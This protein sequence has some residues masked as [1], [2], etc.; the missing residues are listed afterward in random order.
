MANAGKRNEMKAETNKAVSSSVKFLFLAALLMFSFSFI[1]A[2]SYK[3]GNE[4]NLQFAVNGT[5]SS[6]NVTINYP[7]ST[8]LIDNQIAT[9]GSG[10][11]NYTLNSSQ[12]I[13]LGTYQYFPDPSCSASAG[14]FDITPS[15][16]NG[17]NN[18]VF[19][20]VILALLYGL[21]LIF[22]F[23]KVPSFT[24][25]SGMA[26]G[27]FGLYMLR[28]GLIIY[29]NWLTNYISYVTIGVGFGLGL[30]ALVEWIGDT[31]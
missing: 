1:S 27:A 22:F 24:A 10:Y 3:Q 29:Q 7:N 15:G 9:I 26:L 20:L 19:Y 21:T 4:I 25:L 31:I 23:K 2:Y 14:E 30:W 8:H 18:I 13:A 5:P 11:A 17:V 12:T 16:D 6:C 28:S